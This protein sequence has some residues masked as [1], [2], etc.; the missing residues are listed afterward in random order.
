M[1]STERIIKAYVIQHNM[2]VEDEKEMVKSSIDLN[3]QGG[4]S[5]ALPP[6]VQKGGGPNFSEILCRRAS[7]Y[8]QSTHNQLKKILIEQ[9]AKVCQ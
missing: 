2:L 1:K 6:E 8:H 4:S 5:I 3:E 9:L 7:I